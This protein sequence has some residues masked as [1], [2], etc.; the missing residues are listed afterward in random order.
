MQRR[1]TRYRVAKPQPKRS[2]PR[3]KTSK[4]NAKGENV[5][6]KRE[7]RRENEEE[8]KSKRKRRGAVP[9]VSLVTISA[10]SKRNH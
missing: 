1:R 6:E 10:R 4:R 5:E 8:E 7:K 3:L 9:E 2:L